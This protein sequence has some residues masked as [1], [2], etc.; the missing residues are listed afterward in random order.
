M[1]SFAPRRPNLSCFPSEFFTL[2]NLIVS[3][4]GLRRVPAA[5]LLD[6]GGQRPPLPLRPHPRMCY[7]IPL[8]FSP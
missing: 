3:C 6:P 4:S 8:S 5:P 7:R 2:T 1:V